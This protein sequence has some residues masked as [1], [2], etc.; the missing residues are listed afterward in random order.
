[1]HD[2]GDIRTAFEIPEIEKLYGSSFTGGNSIHLLWKNGE[3]FKA[4][5]DY[6]AGA[7]RFVCLEFYIFRNDET[8]IEL[9]ELL[10]KKAAEGVCIYIL[11]DHFGSF[12]T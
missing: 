4:I 12:G 11:Y 9:S 1:M 2:N 7:E 3:L 8:G 6:I 5:F 10:K